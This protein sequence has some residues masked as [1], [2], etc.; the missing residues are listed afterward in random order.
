MLPRSLLLAALLHVWLAL[1][2]GTRVGP[3]LPGQSGWGSLNVTLRGP[4]GSAADGSAEADSPRWRDE[5]PPGEAKSTRH[6]GLLRREPPPPDSGPGAQSQGRW[7]PQALPPDPSRPEIETEGSRG[8]GPLE[9]PAAT[10]VDAVPS[11]EPAPRTLAEPVAAPRPAARPATV[12]PLPPAL[13]ALQATELQPAPA[14][15]ELPPNELLLPNPVRPRTGTESL[16]AAP[17]SLPA[18]P[19]GELPSRLPEP[20]APMPTPRT[21]AAPAPALPR[22]ALQSLPSAAMPSSQPPLVAPV[23][24]RAPS[25]LAGAEA[26]RP[27]ASTEALAVPREQAASAA[28]GLNPLPAELQLPE[29]PPRTLSTPDASRP[30]TATPSLSVPPALTPPSRELSALPAQAPAG[31]RVDEPARSDSAPLTRGDPLAQPVPGPRASS[32]APD[33]GARVGHD[34]ATAP[35]A[36]ASAPLAPLNLQLPRPGAAAMRRGPGML[37]LMPAP[38]ETKSKLEKAIEE[39]KR[40]DCRK[41]HGEKGLLAALPL[42]VDGLRGKGCKW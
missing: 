5:G 14:R 10:P 26:T 28:A 3:A 17:M 15:I 29:A 18:T 6:G 1:M 2:I 37:E 21:L 35:S 34:I 23:P 36:S 41:A 7:K 32:G 24:Q 33:A 8:D 11:P 12:E 38:P 22:T 4:S 9:R 20:P 27:R 40:E 39:A 31:S 25:T 42:A 30:Q 19:L 13:N 16:A